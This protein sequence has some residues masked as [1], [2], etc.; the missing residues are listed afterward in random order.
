MKV[1][2]VVLEEPSAVSVQMPEG[3]SASHLE[4]V[5]SAV[6]AY[7]LRN[8]ADLIDILEAVRN[9]RALDAEYVP[10]PIVVG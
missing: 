10:E 2:C 5:A 7:A 1:A 6:L 4:R 8:G 3:V 9:T